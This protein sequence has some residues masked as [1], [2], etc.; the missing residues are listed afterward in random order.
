MARARQGPRVRA[1]ACSVVMGTEAS[2]HHE[3]L[4]PGESLSSAA[5]ASASLLVMTSDSRAIPEDR[6]NSSGGCSHSASA[7]VIT[8][9]YPTFSSA[10]ASAALRRPIDLKAMWSCRKSPPLSCFTL[11]SF[12]PAGEA[13]GGSARRAARQLGSRGRRRSP[14]VGAGAKSSLGKEGA[15]GA[16]APA[17]IMSSDATR[18]SLSS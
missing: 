9:W 4:A 11:T 2:C 14:V 18:R 12:T 3:P 8:T 1:R 13:G 16:A 6:K 10:R 17:R 5:G 15:A 7:S